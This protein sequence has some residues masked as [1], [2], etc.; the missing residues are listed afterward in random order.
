MAE[1]T[2]TQP[3]VYGQPG[4][5]RLAWGDDGFNTWYL[6]KAKFVRRHLVLLERMD[7]YLAQVFKSWLPEDIIWS[8]E[9]LM[10]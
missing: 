5:F 10:E 8:W 3:A 1:V 4:E 6:A 2:A 9:G 7:P